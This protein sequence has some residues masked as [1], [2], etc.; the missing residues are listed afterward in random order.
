MAPWVKRCFVEVLPKFLFIQRPERSEEPG[1]FDPLPIAPSSEPLSQ[2]DDD[3]EVIKL[4]L[5]MH[6]LTVENI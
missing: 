5:R 1:P 2:H 6:L 4:M 3:D